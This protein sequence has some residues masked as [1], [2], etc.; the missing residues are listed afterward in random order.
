MLLDWLKMFFKTNKS[1]PEILILYR[2][3]V[4]EG[5]IKNIVDVEYPALQRAIETAGQKV[6]INY[7]PKVAFLLANK[8]VPQRVFE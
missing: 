7:N 5:Q 2:E 1:L 4:G 6:K 3:G 8:K